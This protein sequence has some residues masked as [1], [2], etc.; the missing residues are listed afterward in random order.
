MSI[1]SKQHVTE[2]GCSDRTYYTLN[3]INHNIK[4]GISTLL[5]VT[6]EQDSEIKV[7]Q[8]HSYI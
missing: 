7:S 4:S 5:I 3:E 2:N 6:L 8:F 1:T